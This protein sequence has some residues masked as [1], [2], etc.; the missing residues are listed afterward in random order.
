[1]PCPAP[2]LSVDPRR[3]CAVLTQ[4]VFTCNRGSGLLLARRKAEAKCPGGSLASAPGCGGLRAWFLPALLTSAPPP[5]P[6]GERVGGRISE[7][8][9]LGL[10]TTD[11]HTHTH[12]HMAQNPRPSTQKRWKTEKGLR[13]RVLSLCTDFNP[14]RQLHHLQE[15][16][17]TQTHKIKLTAGTHT[18]TE[19][20]VDKVTDVQ[21][22]TRKQS[23][24]MADI[25]TCRHTRGSLGTEDKQTPTI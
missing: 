2:Q 7:L 25:P 19:V 12:I 9:A 1:M 17:N 10:G 15:R 14:H 21:A 3:S 22:D 24:Q 20:P 16:M 8:E 6:T 13:D 11:R 5:S 18:G 4:L 23:H